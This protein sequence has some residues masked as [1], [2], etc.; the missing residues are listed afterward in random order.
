ML[1]FNIP[2]KGPNV[3]LSDTLHGKN[4]DI[5]IDYINVTIKPYINSVTFKVIKGIKC[6]R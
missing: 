3:A 4:G 2:S 5:R 1:V 6:T